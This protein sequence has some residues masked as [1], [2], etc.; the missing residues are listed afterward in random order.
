MLL[1][2]HDS[3]G[4]LVTP[5]AG[6]VTPH[7]CTY[8]DNVNKEGQWLAPSG[9]DLVIDATTAGKGIATYTP[10]FFSGPAVKGR[11]TLAGIAGADHC[12]AS[13]WRIV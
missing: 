6:T 2:F 12:R 1:T 3:A 5:T 11:I 9:G 8:Y 13:F 10:S 4:K 7:M